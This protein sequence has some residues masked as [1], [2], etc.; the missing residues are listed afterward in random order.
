MY[1]E[2]IVST[3][4]KSRHKVATLVFFCSDGEGDSS[5]NLDRDDSSD[6]GDL[7]DGVG[8]DHQLKRQGS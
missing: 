5:D 8:N 7:D 6:D 3:P 2:R 1:G 4:P